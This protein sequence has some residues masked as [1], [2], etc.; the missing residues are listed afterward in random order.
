MSKQSKKKQLNN[1]LDNLFSDIDDS[2][3]LSSLSS[4]ADDHQGWLWECDQNGDFTACSPEVQEILGFNPEEIIGQKLSAFSLNDQ[5]K[6]ELKNALRRKVFPTQANPTYLS[7]DG[8]PVKI[9]LDIFKKTNPDG[10]LIGWNGSARLI[11]T[12]DDIIKTSI[13][14]ETVSKS[15]VLAEVKTQPIPNIMQSKFDEIPAL[16]SDTTKE[17]PK[18]DIEPALPQIVA[19]QEQEPPTIADAPESSAVTL[20]VEKR[21]ETPDIG[22]KIAPDAKGL[23]EIIDTDHER[24]WSQEELIL[25]EQVA[26]QLS[27]A[28]EN[29]N[30]FQQTQE[31]LAETDILYQ[32]SADI[33]AAIDYSEVISSFQKH[34]IPHYQPILSAINWFNSPHN[35]ETLPDWVDVLSRETQLPTQKLRTRYRFSELASIINL[36]SK[37]HIVHIPDVTTD[38]NIDE[39][40]QNTLTDLFSARSIIFIPIVVGG[41]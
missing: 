17:L 34:A 32:A 12:D 21:A 28:M 20:I 2:S 37:D 36:I 41:E 27:L 8:N 25:V 11:T 39:E 18:I 29:A 15:L 4:G 33:N 38:P 3:P 30:L 1:R 35:P 16:K 22:Q 7:S 9:Q 31:A 10:E 13:S 24:E 6:K 14:Q 19:M 40:T 23:L 26:T 5:G